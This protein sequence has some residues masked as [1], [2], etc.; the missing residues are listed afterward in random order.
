MTVSHLLSAPS[1]RFHVPV[2]LL[3]SA[4]VV[5]AASIFPTGAQANPHNLRFVLQDDG[6]I[7]V[8]ADYKCPIGAPNS[9]TDVW[10]VF[11]KPTSVS[12]FTDSHIVHSGNANLFDPPTGTLS[13]T[14]ENPPDEDQV[15]VRVS[16]FAR[17]HDGG[18]GCPATSR[19][20][21]RHT[22]TKT[23][24]LKLNFG[25]ATIADKHYLIND[26]II[27][28]QLPEATPKSSSS[29]TPTYALTPDLPT[30]LD[31]NAATRKI[32]GTPTA[33][34]QATEYTYRATEGTGV[35]E[36]KFILSVIEKPSF[37]NA[38]IPDQVWAAGRA[39]TTL[40]LPMATGDNG[41][42]T[43]SISPALPGSPATFDPAT[44]QISG[45]AQSSTQAS[46]TYTY[47]ATASN[48]RTATLTFSIEVVPDTTPTF[49]DKTVPS[50]SWVTGRNITALQLPEATS[51][52][53]T[54]TYSIATLP[55]GLAFDATTRTISG[56]PTTA[57]RES[58]YTYTATD[59]NG[60][61]DTLPVRI[62]VLENKTPAFSEAQKES[63]GDKVYLKDT[64]ITTL[65]LPNV[66][67]DGNTPLIYAL[68]P[69]LPAGLSYDKTS[70]QITGT[71][72][73]ATQQAITYTYTVTDNDGES[74]ALTFT[75]AVENDTMPSFGDATIGPRV[76]AINTDIRA[77]LP[78]AIGGNGELTYTLTPDLPTGLSFDSK[79]L[80]IS[81]TRDRVESVKEYTYK[82]TDQDGDADERKF[83]IEIAATTPALSFDDDT[84]IADQIYTQTIAIEELQLPKASG[85]NGARSYS[86]S[87][88]LPD[89]LT[90]S[91][92]T[93]TSPPK[94]SGTPTTP[95]E[96]TSYTYKVMDE[97]DG[98][99]KQ[100]VMLPFTIEVKVYD[101][102]PTFG[103]ETIAD[104]NYTSGVEIETLELPQ[105]TG[106]NG[107]L[108]YS[109]SP[110]LPTGL[111]F[112]AATRQLSG[113]PKAVS[114]STSY[115][116]K[117]AD[118]DDDT[119]TLTFTID[120]TPGKV[121]RQALKQTLA[122]G[123]K[124]T[125]TGAVDIIGQRFD[126]SPGAPGLTLGGVA[127]S[128]SES[129]L[130][131]EGTQWDW[132]G[133]ADGQISP[134]IQAMSESDLLRRSA[135]TL[136]LTAAADGEP[137]EGSARP[138]WVVWGRSDWR[139]FEGGKDG[140][141]WDGSQWT[142]WLGVDK[143]LNERVMG[144]V[145]V[146]YGESDADYRA[147]ASEGSL[148]TSVT[149]LWPYVQRTMDNGA[150]VRLVLGVGKGEAEHHTSSD[151]VEKQD[152]SLLAASLSG[153]MPVARWSDFTVS[154][155]GGASLGQFETDGSAATSSLGGLTATSWRLRGSIE[156]EHDGFALTSGS[157]WLI[158]PRA[159]LALRQDGGDGVTGTGVELSGGV[160]LSAP[161][162]RFSFD[163]SGHWLAL[164]SEDETKEWGASL[165]ARFTPQADGRG[166]SLALG[167]AWGQQQEGV[168]GNDQLFNDARS[169]V[170]QD[171]SL[172]A[173]AG[174]GFA[175][176]GGLL[177]PFA[178]M[179]LAGESDAQHYRT[180]LRFARNDV[181][182]ALTA[183]HH[184][185]TEP[186]NRIGLDL[187]LDF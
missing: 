14:I 50:Q 105:A 133:R 156:A 180:G 107:T 48:N 53:G 70:K 28:L 76:W 78:A 1:A 176:A 36:L 136:P 41:M 134:Q 175:A 164:H 155:I 126:A 110:A 117:V 113:T 103:D 154:A 59:E 81:G 20:Q 46:T 22:D 148:E 62:E 177:T 57:T 112:D 27:E 79:M 24:N 15:D 101:T 91:P 75:I 151:T 98:G 161:D 84:P 125:I 3:A 135:F 61:T 88:A 159:A 31:F 115:T 104:Q 102:A 68:T 4:L 149:A 87:P 147:G 67:T 131:T 171:L 94:I 83:T 89:G 6:K 32:T 44:R 2:G 19:V 64:A 153:R 38:S 54:L 187:R 170:S 95:Q 47:T 142:G 132:V 158:R 118:E 179:T 21:W 181:N 63:I 23:I 100:E 186:D 56:K 146:S 114:P 165:E 157:S 10:R 85:G 35:A 127:V 73:T 7:N 166:L 77:Q 86:I 26:D 16:T 99:D 80:V 139:G 167:P 5:S 90:F 172:T 96:K 144:G 82:V 30:G 39:I 120:V 74:D 119:A 130:A 40:T 49:G 124:A 174:Y 25:S 51:G 65:N 145:A 8:K 183:T 92:E 178:D 55:A 121:E 163:A 116:Y 72:T 11:L 9:L 71:P 162:S 45:R 141:T 168:L 143:W 66:A 108:S 184:A 69:D 140:S 60:D 129:A 122:A 43:Y 97:G 185:G 52:N 13:Y 34:Q 128:D 160:R 109:I 138:P 182:A 169:A 173:S 150:A 18:T 17:A 123:A 37:G 152:L 12:Q 29:G 33:T 111:S 137:E 42:V 106:G 58:D 93:E